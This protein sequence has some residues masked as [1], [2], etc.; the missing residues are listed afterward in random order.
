MVYCIEKSDTGKIFVNLVAE[1]DG[2]RELLAKV[3]GS[4]A[5]ENPPEPC[6]TLGAVGVCIHPD[7]LDGKQHW[8]PH[9]PDCPND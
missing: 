4:I 6:D 9:E 8:Y 2:D 3:D 1:S 7:D 5:Y